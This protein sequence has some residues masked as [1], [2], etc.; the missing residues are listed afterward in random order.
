[1]LTSKHAYVVSSARHGTTLP[2]WNQDGD[3]RED[4]YKTLPLIQIFVRVMP[5]HAKNALAGREVEAW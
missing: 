1:M 5:P 2:D 3:A 4:R